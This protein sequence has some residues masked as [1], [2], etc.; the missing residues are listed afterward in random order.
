MLKI[1]ADILADIGCFASV[2]GNIAG[3]STSQGISRLQMLTLCRMCAMVAFSV[4]SVGSGVMRPKKG[5][6]S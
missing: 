3:V 2:S 6:W 4:L 1:Y 5:D